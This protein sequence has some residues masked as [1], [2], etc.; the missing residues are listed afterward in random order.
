MK[1][2]IITLLALT[3]IFTSCKKGSDDTADPVV[4]NST[5]NSVSTVPS[6]FTQKVLLE[7]FTGAGQSQ[8][9]D[10]FVK[11]KSIIDGYSTTA[12]PVRIHYSDAMEIA[13]YTS[14][15]STFNNGN[16]PT[17]PS[18]MVN[19]T[20]S[21]GMVIL[22]RTQW[23]SN[24]LTAKSK[25]ATCGLAIITSVSGNIATIE[26][27]SGFKQ[28]LTGT[29]NLTVMLTEDNVTGNGNQFDQRNSYNTTAGHTYY[30]SGDPIVGFNHTHT[31]RKLITATLGD[32][33]PSAVT[34]ASGEYVKTFTVNIS[35]YKAA[36]LS[37]VAFI[38][39]EGTT[40]TTHEVLNAQIVKLGNTQ[41]WD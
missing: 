21:L 6:T 4:D 11:E 27:H 3:V 1:T 39:K 41:N 14:M 36:D 15:E 19:R 9:T 20:P 17:F 24:F 12:I 37:V 32:L 31:L 30:G 10:G 38:N 16:P 2:S 35:A 7:I 33:I 34:S 29:I 28:A 25:T 8:C 22:N 26:V 13:Y 23:M 18:A 40:S 5:N